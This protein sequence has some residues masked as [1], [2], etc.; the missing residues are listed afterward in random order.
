[1]GNKRTKSTPKRKYSKKLDDIDTE[2]GLYTGDEKPKTNPKVSKI[3]PEVRISKA[4]IAKTEHRR[5]RILLGISSFLLLTYP[6]LWFVAVISSMCP[7]SGCHNPSDIAK[8]DSF[9]IKATALIIYLLLLLL[10]IIWL[11]VSMKVK[12]KN[13]SKSPKTIRKKIA[14]WTI[15]WYLLVVLIL[16]FYFRLI[17]FK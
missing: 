7:A 10:I 12:Q 1:M 16:A 15:A 3:N 11:V 14:I 4:E 2:D 17:S 5:K 6:I 9:P 13:K 8:R